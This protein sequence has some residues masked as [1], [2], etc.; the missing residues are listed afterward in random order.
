MLTSSL[1]RQGG[2]LLTAVRP[3]AHTLMSSGVD[4]R[5]FG[6]RDI[7]TERDM[8]HWAPLPLRS[9]PKSGPSAFGYM[10][11]LG[12]AIDAAG[13][14]LLHVH[15]LWT[16]ASVATFRWARRFLRPYVVSPHG[17]LEPWAVRN[18]RWKKQV[19]G[20]LYEN[21]HL[22][23]AACLHALAG[24]E[25]DAIRLYGLT[26]PICIIPNGVDLPTFRSGTPPAWD[27][28]LPSGAKV[29]LFL[30]RIHPKKGLRELLHGWKLAV[31]SRALTDD[32]FLVI[33]GWDQNGYESELKGLTRQIDIA[34]RVRFVGPQFG[35]A[36]Q[37]SFERAQ[38]FILPSFSEGLPM[39]VLEAWSYRLPVLMTPQCNLPDGFEDGAALS[40]DPTPQSLARVLGELADMT[41]ED[42]DR[43]GARGY[44]LVSRRYTWVKVANDMR[45]VYCWVVGGGQPPASVVGE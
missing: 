17:M 16:Y 25:A 29:L 8:Y 33:A 5:I 21:A 20:S 39:A 28:N 13:L 43:M 38:A 42:M 41:N 44:A 1:S 18:S 2:G 30:G 24:A 7:D 32:W 15:G 9:F 14:D 3:L 4:V 11:G 40:T 22:G 19:A 12:P 23:G 35:E 27:S 36:K 6:G 10:H 37:Q 31:A 26:N 45:E 34:D